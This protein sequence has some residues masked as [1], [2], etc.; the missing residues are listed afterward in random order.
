MRPTIGFLHPYTLKGVIRRKTESEDM[1]MIFSEDAVYAG[2]VYV[3]E[4][5]ITS[6]GQKHYNTAMKHFGDLDGMGGVPGVAYDVLPKLELS[7][8]KIETIYPGEPESV[9]AGINIG[10]FIIW[11]SEDIA[12]LL[13]KGFY[14]N[15]SP[16]SNIPNFPIDTKQHAEI[17]RAVSRFIADRAN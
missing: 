13:I 10:R 6:E 5:A 7:P 8:K 17:R 4:F 11:G 1:T 16:V 3:R 15:P 9:E 12:S 2:M 14:F